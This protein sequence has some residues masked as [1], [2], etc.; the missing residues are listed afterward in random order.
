MKTKPPAQIA[1]ETLLGRQA[2]SARGLLDKLTEKGYD[3]PEAIAAVRRLME[4]GY[5]DDEGYARDLAA[6]LTRRG[7][8]ARRVRQTLIAKGVDAETADEAIPEDQDAA[9]AQIERWLSKLYKGKPLDAKEKSRLY[10]ALA[11]RGFD[12]EAIR[13]GLRNLQNGFE[14][15]EDF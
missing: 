9:A 10:G 1:A 11:R 7:Y 12:G 3:E 15:D 13:R 6:S 14:D 5:L 4:L 8:G 2:Y